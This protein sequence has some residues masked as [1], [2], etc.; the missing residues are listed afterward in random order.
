MK[1]LTT[2]AFVAMLM[3]IQTVSAQNRY[4]KSYEDFLEGRW[5]QLDTIYIDSHSKGHQAW[6]GGND[7]TLTTDNKA[8]NKILKNDAF[9]VMLGDIIYLN[10]RNLRYDKARFG[11]GY[12]IARRIGERSLLFVNRLIGRT[13]E[14]DIIVVG[15]AFGAIGAAISANKQIKN[16][17]CYVISSG[18]DEK[19]R[20][21]IR[22]IDD[23][24]M[25]QM[26]DNRGD[27]LDEY[28]A[29]K[30]LKKRLLATHVI[31]ILE[32]TSLFE[33]ANCQ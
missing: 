20:I 15:A 11:N 29:E 23:H 10:C 32:K 6:W 26:I 12:T 13:Q 25:S 14:K 5:E 33:Q 30:D 24:L 17:V 4:C 19:G 8:T 9:A 7:Y 18:A 31:P 21:G 2:A 3:L 1:E 28:Y 22:P 27:L 16:Q